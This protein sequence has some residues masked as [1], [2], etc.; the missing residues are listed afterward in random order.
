MDQWKKTSCI[1]CANFCGLEV[2]VENN[3]IIKVRGDKDNPRSEG[4]VCR[5]GLNIKYVQHHADRLMYPQKKVGEHF[6]RIPWDQAISEIGQR[7]SAILEENGPRSFALMG[8]GPLGAVL[9][10]PFATG[11]LRGLGSQYLYHP[12]AQELTGRFWVCGKTFGSEHAH[13]MPDVDHT[14]MLLAVGCN[15]MMSHNYFPQARRVLKRFSEDNEKLFVVV[16]P[17][18]SETAKIANLHLPIRPG[19]D[20]LLYRAMI[21]MI[22][23]EGWQNQDYIDKHV[24]GLE[25]ISSMLADFDSR[26]AV[27]VC[28]LD[29]DT[30]KEVCRQFATRRSCLHSDL[31][32]LMTRHST[33]ISF[34][35]DILRAIC[36]RIG[37]MGGSVFPVNFLGGQDPYEQ[38]SWRTQVTD[39]PAIAGF[40][41]PNAMPEEILSGHPERLRAV[42]VSGCNPLRSYADT[43]AYE[44]AFK[45]LDLLVTV[46]IAMT[47]TAALSHYVLPALSPFE[48]WDLPAQ[49][50]GFPKPFLQLRQPVVEAEG[51]QLEASE[52]FVRLADRL[53]LVP[54]IPDPVYQVADS[55]NRLA[56]GAALTGYLQSK[57]EAAPKMP[58]ILAKTL[59]KKLGS[60]NMA[61]FWGM[62][63]MLPPALHEIA[64]RVGF[65][66]GPG[67]GEE[68]FQAVLEHPEG[69]FVGE[70]DM[71]T[72]DYFH[73]MATKD[74]RINLIV[75]ELTK[76]LQEI[77]PALELE[78]LNKD[79]EEYPFILSSG[80]HWDCNA[81]TTIR[82]PAWNRGK[83]ACTALMHSADA[84]DLG[85]AD[86][87]MIKVMTDG[88]E[89][90]IEL[91]V[92]DTTRRG[93]IMIPHGFGLVHQGQ[94]F[95]AN[96]N[97]LA[98][99]THR[100]R[101][102]GTP[103]HRYI[104]CRVEAMPQS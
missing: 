23:N 43:S 4:Y 82:D 103:L 10:A 14:D 13:L 30:V 29:Y 94:T 90:T 27:A 8:G 75:P 22:L 64:K 37:V 59:G 89:E 33:L 20:A 69:L 54:E 87:Q 83:R 39:F 6:E 40:Y 101:I 34:L 42:I 80:R 85:L 58:Y 97:R 48:S 86:G 95:G 56:F 9:Q 60:S 78:K 3:R 91:E 67:L 76:W 55:G 1:L 98:K 62:L 81:N 57:P 50:G 21:S 2:Q 44:E 93:Y 74:K 35:E 11:V 77:E 96:A 41:P 63:Q 65:T 66:P 45:R 88:G 25:N 73:T 79:A 52:V 61:V 19:T 47:E 84:A 51:E 104:P 16:D 49:I 70:A 31:G 36:G 32:V 24:S 12:L 7:L 102:A 38:E 92:T 53:G 46:E 68:I 26:A 72:F 99:N 28:E 100:D 5:K 15:P 18:R 71:E 17:R